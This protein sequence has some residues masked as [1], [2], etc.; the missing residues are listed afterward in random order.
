[1]AHGGKPFA[2]STLDIKTP[3]QLTTLNVRGAAC[4]LFDVSMGINHEKFTF[5]NI[6]HTY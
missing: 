6:G 3:R 2:R 4:D 1:M 5:G